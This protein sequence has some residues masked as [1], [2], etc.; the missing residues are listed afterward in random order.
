[1]W[2]GPPGDTVAAVEL[3][4]SEA[5]PVCLGWNRAD[6]QACGIFEEHFSDAIEADRESTTVT[7]STQH[8]ILDDTQLSRLG[9][10]ESQHLR[11]ASFQLFRAVIFF[12]PGI[13]TFLLPLCG[14]LGKTICE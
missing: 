4:A 3:L 13:E 14:P 6:H 10:S 7:N 1:M 9:C 8:I 12:F 2:E 5:S 11:Q